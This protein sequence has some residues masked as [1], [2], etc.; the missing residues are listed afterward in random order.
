L[1]RVYGKSLEERLLAAGWLLRH[2]EP[3]AVEKILPLDQARTTPE[4]LSLWMECQAALGN[5]QE[6]IKITDSSPKV[7][8]SGAQRMLRG[9]ALKKTGRADEGRKEYRLGLAECAND[10]PQLI[11]SLAFLRSDGEEE[12]FLQYARPLLAN[13]TTALT[14]L[15]QLAPA[16]ARSGD[17]KALRDFLAIAVSAGPLATYPPLLDDMAYLDMVLGRS[18]NRTEIENR[19]GNF[20]DNPA[21]QFTLALWQLLQGQKAPGPPDLQS[22]RSPNPRSDTPAA[23][24]TR[25]R[26]CRQRRIGRCPK[27]RQ[28]SH[29]GFIH[30]SG[31]RPAL[32]IPALTAGSLRSLWLILL[33]SR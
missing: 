33:D 21:Y 4:T 10:T 12:I 30:K 23:A 17:A 5:W 29:L 18:V 15:Q 31:T 16:V 6:L 13:E 22:K 8:A 25:L 27:D 3:S 28:T 11:S 20:P 7:F 26:P 1:A 19:A 14:A 32:K 9:Q 24:H 2:G